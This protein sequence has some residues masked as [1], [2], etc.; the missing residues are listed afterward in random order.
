MEILVHRCEWCEKIA[1]VPCCL[2]LGEGVNSYENS[3]TPR[4][5]VRKM[6]DMQRFGALVA[7][8]RLWTEWEPDI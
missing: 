5:E 7:D 4:A 2:S 8:A 6:D 1:G 3:T